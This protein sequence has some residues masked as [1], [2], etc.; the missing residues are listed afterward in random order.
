M[1]GGVQGWVWWGRGRE[2]LSARKKVGGGHA[3]FMFMGNLVFVYM[4][5][6]FTFNTLFIVL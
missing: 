2:V 6:F 3:S 5:F 1:G 4:S